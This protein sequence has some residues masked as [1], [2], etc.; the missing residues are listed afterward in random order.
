MRATLQK[1]Y[2]LLSAR[3]RKQAVWVFLLMLLVA[4]FETVGVA[5]ILPLISVL[6]DPEMIERNKYLQLAYQ[7]SGVESIDSFV[8]VLGGG[9]LLIFFT[10]LTLK[11][12]SQWVQINFTKMRVHSLGCRLTQRYLAQEYSWFL[13]RHTSMITT[14]ILAE[15]NKVISGSLFPTMQMISHGIVTL[16]LMILLLMIEPFLALAATIGLAGAYGLIYFAVRQPLS[17]F[18]RWRQQAN[19]KR[20]KVTQET[21]GGVKDVKVR[22]IEQLMVERFEKPSLITARQEIRIDIIKAIPGF[23]MQAFVFGGV[24][25]IMLYLLAAYGSMEGAL[26]VLATFAFAGYRLMPALQSIFRNLTSLRSMAPAL[27]ALIQD[28]RH[29]APYNAAADVP[30]GKRMAAPEKGLRLE[31]VYY[32]YPNADSWALKNLTIDIKA[33]QQV[34]LVGATGS[35]KSTTVDLILGLLTPQKGCIYVDGT[36][37]DASNV[38]L[39]QRIIGYVPQDI[40]LSDDTVA[41]NIAF[42]LPEHQIDHEAV[43]KAAK[44]AN[45]HDFILE[46]L[47]QG[48]QTFVGERGTRL[49]GGQKQRIGIARA[50]Y[51]D[52]EVIVMDEATSAL[53]N[54]TERVIMEA[55]DNLAGKKTVIMI[56]HRLTTVRNCDIIYYLHRG[57]VAAQGSYEQLLELSPEFRAM[58]G[59]A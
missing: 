25:A 24:V 16:F 3:E 35:G 44:T 10:S 49:S 1:L 26:P 31:G 6:S 42:G 33:H 52:P 11:A 41:G 55:V 51:Y 18:G 19:M 4:F 53:D 43:V 40:F 13:Q 2:E 15:I 37:I 48:Y 22:G 5:S 12:M 29:L 58:A 46:E 8:L 7:H 39:W 45:L 30:E 36:V 38:R 32:K 59:V 54:T 57:E 17:R 47:P 27:E 21:F 28:L 20:Y 23:F 9:F 34:A 50:L 14:T 56:A